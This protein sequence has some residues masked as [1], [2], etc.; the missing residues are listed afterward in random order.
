MTR[1]LTF[2]VLA[3][4]L[5]CAAL[6]PI[7]LNFGDATAIYFE[8]FLDLFDDVAE[9]DNASV[10]R[11][12]DGDTIVV[13]RHPRLNMLETVRLIG[14]DTPETVHPTKAVEYF[15]KEASNFAKTLLDGKKVI[16]SYDWD[17][18]D[19]YNRVLAYVWLPA[20]YEGE[21]YNILFNLASISSGYGFVYTSFAFKNYYMEIFIEA[22]RYARLNSVG[23]W[24]DKAFGEEPETVPAPEY[25]PIVYI[26]NTGTKYHR[27]G[28]R[29]LSSSKIA[30]RLSEAIRRGYGP[31]SVCRP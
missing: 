7:T 17:S 23:L 31:C 6:T 20:T 29:Y 9:Y 8:E 4:S 15:G 12:I 13:I 10:E 2:M 5:F 3:L 30:I 26:T 14:L 27:D 24:A 28:C 18:R 11:V 19:K 16:L 22:E 1:F 25:D 21:T